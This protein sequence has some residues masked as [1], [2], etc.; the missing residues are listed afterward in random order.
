M[1]LYLRIS[2]K[3]CISGIKKPPEEPK[4]NSGSSPRLHGLDQP[5]PA[6]QAP[7]CYGEECEASNCSSYIPTSCWGL[8]KIHDTAHQA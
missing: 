3:T 5:L 6:K 7:Y 1:L 8:T 4:L 2:W